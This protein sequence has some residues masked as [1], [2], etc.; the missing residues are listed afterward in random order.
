MDV[1]QKKKPNF[2]LLKYMLAFN[3]IESEYVRRKKKF[4]N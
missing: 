3:K 4:H 1:K 2:S